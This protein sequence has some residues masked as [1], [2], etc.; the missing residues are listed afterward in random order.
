MLNTDLHNPAITPKISATEYVQSCHRCLPL[1]HLPDQTLLSVYESIATEPL[2]IAPSVNR[3]DSTIRCSQLSNDTESTATYS[4]YS[5]LPRPDA[6]SVPSDVAAAQ[7]AAH[8]TA[9][10]ARR[11]LAGTAN[12]ALL[13]RASTSLVPSHIGGQPVPAVD[14]AVAYWN[15]VDA[16]R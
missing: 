10:N 6:C 12:G 2:Q 7:V 1:R 14:W 16:G 11:S 4:I 15:L 13:S 5:S 3:V 8:A 9:N